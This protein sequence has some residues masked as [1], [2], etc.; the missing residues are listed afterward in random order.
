MQVVGKAARKPQSKP[1]PA[2]QP[3]QPAGSAAGR[4][5][6]AGSAQTAPPYKRCPSVTS[7]SDSTCSGESDQSMASASGSHAS[8][9]QPHPGQPSAAARPTR[10]A[11]LP[12]P[13][14]SRERS[15]DAAG[16]PAGGRHAC[17]AGVSTGTA[18]GGRQHQQQ[19][20]TWAGKVAAAAKGTQEARPGCAALSRQGCAQRPSSSHGGDAAEPQAALAG[21]EQHRQQGAACSS[22]ELAAAR[23][24]AEAAAAEKLALAAEVERLRAALT[25]SESV[26][27]QEV[28]RLLQHAVAHEAQV[29]GRGVLQPESGPRR[30]PSLKPLLNSLDS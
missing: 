29:R 5:A 14:S 4:G 12:L 2:K 16:M 8:S 27:Q 28:A 6:A 15:S 7:L 24:A 13:S 18:P 26:R 23:A 3:A 25:Q 10:P 19:P 9:S 22:A 21:C 20:H 17:V 1:Q 11:Q 30:L